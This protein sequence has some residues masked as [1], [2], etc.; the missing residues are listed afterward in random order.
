[1]QPSWSISTLA[2]PSSNTF[3]VGAFSI[4]VL[5]LS[6]RPR[7]SSSICSEELMMVLMSLSISLRSSSF[8]GVSSSLAFMSSMYFPISSILFLSM[9]VIVLIVALT[10]FSASL[11]IESASRSHETWMKA[12][13]ATFGSCLMTSAVLQYS[14]SFLSKSRVTGFLDTN[15]SN[16]LFLSSFQMCWCLRQLSMYLVTWETELEMV[17]LMVE[18]SLFTSWFLLM[19]RLYENTTG[20][21]SSDPEGYWGGVSM[22]VLCIHLVKALLHRARLLTSLP[23]S[24]ETSTMGGWITISGCTRMAMILKRGWGPVL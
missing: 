21:S 16:T 8:V 9:S 17:S 10:Q 22:H 6:S 20:S 1:M 19:S 4:L 24:F 15:L 13:W 3:F 11:M 2:T 7:M 18:I 23:R 14:S 12:H 5:Y